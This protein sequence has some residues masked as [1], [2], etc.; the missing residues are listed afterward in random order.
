MKH[1]FRLGVIALLSGCAHTAA[2]RTAWNTAEA[3][4]AVYPISQKSFWGDKR[5][6]IQAGKDYRVI[7]AK[8]S[9]FVD[10]KSKS[11]ASTGE[12]IG[13]ALLDFFLDVEVLDNTLRVSQKDKMD[14]TVQIHADKWPVA[15][16]HKLIGVVSVY[17]KEK[18]T[19]LRS[20][21]SQIHC[22]LTSPTQSTYSAVLRFNENGYLSGELQHDQVAIPIYASHQKSGEKKWYTSS[23]SSLPIGFELRNE[24]TTF[25]QIDNLNDNDRLALFSIHDNIE[26]PAMIATLLALRNAYNRWHDSVDPHGQWVDQAATNR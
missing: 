4:V 7:D 19:M 3:P 11:T 21:D 5:F 26:Q 13:N 14:Q 22:Q 15:C 16:K 10:S 23:E 17:E 2:Q 8:T 25:A 18:T 6:H 1:L 9:W 12:K 20:M 24:G